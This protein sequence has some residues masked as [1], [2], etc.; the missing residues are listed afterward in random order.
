MSSTGA[1]SGAPWVHRHHPPASARA[2]TP[3]G[4]SL[5][6]SRPPA[7][8]SGCASRAC[9]RKATGSTSVSPVGDL[10][11]AGDR[12]IEASRREQRP[13]VGDEF[14]GQIEPAAGLEVVRKA[15][16][17]RWS[18]ADRNR[19]ATSTRLPST[20]QSRWCAS[21]CPKHA[22]SSSS[23]R[24]ANRLPLSAMTASSR[25]NASAAFACSIDFELIDG[26]RDRQLEGVGCAARGGVDPWVRLA[27]HAIGM[28]QQ[29]LLEIVTAAALVDLGDLGGR[30]RLLPDGRCEDRPAA[31]LQRF[32]AGWRSPSDMGAASRRLSSSLPTSFV[33]PRG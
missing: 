18:G 22:A 16:K 14:R 8:R 33:G 3:G 15:S 30:P 23:L 4:R 2:P 9:R 12:D 28:P 25:R 21:S 24:S 29:L 27:L 13:S 19:S 6:D 26:D 11:Q 20:V 17:H 1:S 5:G 32:R 31:R 7:P 10:D